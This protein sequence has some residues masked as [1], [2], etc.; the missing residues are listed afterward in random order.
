MTSKFHE[1]TADDTQCVVP[2][3]QPFVDGAL[4]S[5]ASAATFDVVN[6]SN[7][8]YLLSIPVGCETDVGCAVT[9]ARRAFVEG[10]WSIA[11][12]SFKKEVLHRFAKLISVSAASLDAL[13]A[14]EMGKPVKEA[15][16]NARE[17]ASLMRF[18]AEAVDK[19]TGDSYSSDQHSLAVQ[20]RVP[21]GVVAAVVP[22]NFPTFNVVLKIAPALAAGNSVVLK[23]SELSSR[24][25]MRLG[26]LA[27]DAG[28]PPG[29]LNV[30]PGLGETVGC[31]LG[32]HP[33]VDMVTFT[34][35]TAVGKKML[36][37][38]GQ[39]NMKVVMAECGGKA[40]Q[41][42]FADMPNLDAVAQQIAQLLVTNQ[43]QICA[44]GSRL[45]VERSI[46]TQ[47]VEMILLRV[48]DVV[49]GDA[50][51]PQTTFGPLASAQQCARV[52]R[53]IE[54]GEREGATLAAGGGRVLPDS[55]GYFVEPT[56]FRN[57]VPTARIAQEEIFGPV[58]S[59]IA[60][61]DEAEAIRIANGTIYGLV[62]YAWTTDLS[63]A[64]RLI[65]GIR[66]SLLINAVP[67]TGEGP[68][69]AFSSEPVGQSGTGTEGGL[70]G[71]ESYMRRQTVWI[72]HA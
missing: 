64:M 40:P 9:S 37:Y 19:V 3:V 20:R 21:R 50:L 55:G 33:D 45:L 70:P 65:K 27:I 41:I 13:D 6:P 43:G 52:M 5:P 71:M 2:A 22:W 61:D 12:P 35:S 15:Y 51:E 32:L 1:L 34:G 57:V 62:A 72:N 11:S 56:I 39:S 44:V 59:V 29:V 14:E 25:A 46:E 23:P 49:I 10:L 24:S 67:P 28:L 63:R 8:K 68:G 30:V 42:V 69:N 36:Q 38:S 58:L 48:R 47:L 7:G 60:F 16:A 53:Y 31:A 17:A 26:Q 54:L 18:Y 66:S 4:L